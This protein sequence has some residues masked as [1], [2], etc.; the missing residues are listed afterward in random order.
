MSSPGGLDVVLR[1]PGPGPIRVGLRVDG[2]DVLAPS[3]IDPGAERGLAWRNL[4]VGLLFVEVASTTPDGRH[5]ST[6]RSIAV[7]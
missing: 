2:V 4:P 1:N 6:C 3:T 7:S 5:R